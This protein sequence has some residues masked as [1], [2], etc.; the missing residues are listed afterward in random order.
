M[1]TAHIKLTRKQKAFAD[2]LLK[3]KK[4][5]ATQAILRTYNVTPKGSTARTIAAQNLAK[6]SIQAYLSTHDHESQLTI[7]EMMKQREDKRLA[8]D[9]AR[10]IQDRLHGK[11][12]QRTEVKTTG[13][14]LNLDLTSSLEEEA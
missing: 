12:T 6:P 10:D 11:A 8:F 1:K 9:S 4:L 5:S 13:I 14:T 2:E 3:D 7:V